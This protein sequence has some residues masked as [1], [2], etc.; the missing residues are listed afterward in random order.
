[1]KMITPVRTFGMRRS[2]DL[3]QPSSTGSFSVVVTD[4]KGDP[5][6]GAR[7][8]AS[9]GGTD[10]GAMQTD[11]HGVAV[12]NS[13]PGQ[14]PVQVRIDA[15]P[16]VARR[17]LSADA[18]NSGETLFVELPVDRPEPLLTAIEIC[19]LLAGAGAV[20][21]GF[22]YKAEALKLAGEIILGAGIFTTIYRHGS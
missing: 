19:T 7:V 16:Y 21:A 15:T 2:F 20:G 17:T 9:R 14:D 12:F 4:V 1:M 3:G 18:A 10:L 8:T 6:E 22:Y 5:F 13:S 11:S